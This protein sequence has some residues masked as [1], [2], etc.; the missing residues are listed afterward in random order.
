MYDTARGREIFARLPE[1]ESLPGVAARDDLAFDI[2]MQLED[3]PAWQA[4]WPA[5]REAIEAIPEEF[6]PAVQ[7]SRYPGVAIAFARAGDLESARALLSELPEGN[8]YADLTRVYVDGLAGDGL[9]VEQRM[10]TLIEQAPEIAYGEFFWSDVALQQ[11]DVTRAIDLLA[12]AHRKAPGWADPLRYWGDALAQNGQHRAA[13][14]RYRQAAERAPRWG[15]LHIA[16]GRAEEARG[17]TRQA[18]QLY[19]QAVTMDM[20]AA[21]RQTVEE[22]L[23]ALSD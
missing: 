8:Y 2:A 19:E 6:R 15:A 20:S 7:T 23:E 18:R 17:R 10:E 4:Q 16:W 12:A 1:Y 21:D 9:A 5:I 14:H 13:V 3:T 11:G 22:R